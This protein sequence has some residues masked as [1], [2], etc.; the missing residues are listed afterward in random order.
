MIATIAMMTT[1]HRRRR[2]LPR[3]NSP[4]EPALMM[5]TP[6]TRRMTPLKTMCTPV[7]MGAM[8]IAMVAMISSPMMPSIS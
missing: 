3:R 5:V 6:P 2:S 7:M 1:L 8:M 4:G